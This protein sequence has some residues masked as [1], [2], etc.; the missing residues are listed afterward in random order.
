MKL[1]GYALGPLPNLRQL[2][3]MEVLHLTDAD[4]IY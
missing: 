3:S 1:L 4:Q 2:A